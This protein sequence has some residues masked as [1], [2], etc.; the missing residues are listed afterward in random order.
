MILKRLEDLSRQFISHGMSFLSTHNKHRRDA[1]H[2]MRAGVA[3]NFMRIGF[4][5][6][7]FLMDVPG[8]L[9]LLRAQEII[10]V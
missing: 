5:A 2:Q 8:I 9:W 10:S 4:D 3:S 6:G 7:V 1:E